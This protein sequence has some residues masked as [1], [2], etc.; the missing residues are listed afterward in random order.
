MEL[1]EKIRNSIRAYIMADALGVP[2][3]FKAKGTF[4]CNTFASGG[5]HNQ[6]KG[7]WSDDSSVLLCLIDAF[8]NDYNRSQQFEIFKQNMKSWYHNQKFNAGTGL[9]DIGTQTRT[10]L[11]QGGSEESE[12]MGNGALFYALPIAIIC[13]AT[14][15]SEFGTQRLFELFCAF[16]HNNRNCFKFGG[17]FCLLI[18]K[19]LLDLPIES[20][21]VTKYENRGDVINTYNLVI[22]NFLANQNTGSFLLDDICSVVNLGEDTD[23]N[24]AL[25]AALM[26]T[27]KEVDEKDWKQVK[28]YDE[29]DSA[30]D[31][32]INSVGL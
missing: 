22:D 11:I 13:S 2:Y 24:A 8:S 25:F 26:G 5:F 7:T 16:T 6:P 28:R 23:T 15:Y 9:F 14:E 20:I 31:T 32:L 12:S 17:A 10:A 1:K 18:R 4:N 29:I 30:I 27:K 19:L 21:E 3:E